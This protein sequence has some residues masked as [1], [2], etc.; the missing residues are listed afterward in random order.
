MPASFPML[1]CVSSCF[2]MA[3]CYQMLVIPTAKAWGK[4]LGLSIELFNQDDME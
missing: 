2:S 3:Y 1:L 4:V